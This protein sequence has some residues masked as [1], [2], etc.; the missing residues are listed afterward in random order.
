MIQTSK[1]SLF[2]V[3]VVVV[4]VVVKFSKQKRSLSW[5]LTD[6]TAGFLL[7]FFSVHQPLSLENSSCQAMSIQTELEHF[8]EY[9]FGFCA[10]LDEEPGLRV[11]KNNVRKM[12][13]HF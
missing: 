11:T 3:V 7:M 10:A 1:C 5:H 12:K 6:S 9:V 8:M 2:V 4:V 13:D